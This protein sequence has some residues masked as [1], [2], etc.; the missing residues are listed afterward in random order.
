MMVFQDY[1]RARGSHKLSLTRNSKNCGERIGL[2]IHILTTVPFLEANLLPRSKFAK[3]YALARKTL[4]QGKTVH[5]SRSR[6][7]GAQ[8]HIHYIARSAP[9]RS[10]AHQLMHDGIPTMVPVCFV[11]PHGNHP[12]LWCDLFRSSVFGHIILLRGE[13]PANSNSKHFTDLG[14]RSPPW[15][16]VI[17][18]AATLGTQKWQ[19]TNCLLYTSPSPRDGLLS[20]MPSSA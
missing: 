8:S 11:V 5:G 10:S 1:S 9:L 17:R 12:A 16:K 19:D 7:H 6:C 14:S 2:R 15:I 4:D 13:Q 18:C 20:R 3:A